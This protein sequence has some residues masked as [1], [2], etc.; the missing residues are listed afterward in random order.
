M[1]IVERGSRPVVVDGHPLRFSVFRRDNR[2]WGD[3]D[4]LQVIIVDESRR[5]SILRICY[6][7]E[8]DERCFERPITPRM[9]AE[10]AR[11]A[12]ARGWQPG[13]GTGVFLGIPAWELRLALD[14]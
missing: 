13:L 12:L 5:G 9:I 14:R 6:L 3:Y 1:T 11:C 10:A 7:R 2:D 4:Q 8:D